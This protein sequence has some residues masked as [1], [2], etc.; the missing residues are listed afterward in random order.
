[1]ANAD[2]S[3]IFSCD[4][5]S[6]KAQKKLSKLRDEI[7]ELNSKLEKETGNKMNLERSLTPHLRQRKL[8]R[9]A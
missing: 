4:L 2:G 5:D 9:N 8:L 1:M 7:S 6:T 3:V